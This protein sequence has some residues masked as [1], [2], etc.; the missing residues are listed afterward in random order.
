MKV[1]SP[2]HLEVPIGFGFLGS[3]ADGLRAVLCYAGLVPWFFAPR[4]RAPPVPLRKFESLK[5]QGRECPLARP[6]QPTQRLFCTQ[7]PARSGN[8]SISVEA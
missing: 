2:V 1:G 4:S 5:K 8:S 7:M 6:C 3:L